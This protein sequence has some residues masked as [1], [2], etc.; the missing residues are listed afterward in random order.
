[1]DQVQ[2]LRAPGSRAEGVGRILNAM[3]AARAPLRRG[4]E[5]IVAPLEHAQDL[6]KHAMSASVM[7]VWVH[8][9]CEL[10]AGTTSLDTQWQLVKQTGEFIQAEFESRLEDPQDVYLSAFGAAGHIRQLRAATPAAMTNPHIAL[11]KSSLAI[12]KRAFKAALELEKEDQR[13]DL[14]V[15]AKA[16]NHAAQ[17]QA[18]VDAL[19]EL[20]VQTQA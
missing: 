12:E 17:H 14:Q 9:R 19:R 11:L 6:L 10:I 20:G 2:R 13:H 4:E 3:S 18:H 8:A 16:V 7:S 1:M 15:I 5:H